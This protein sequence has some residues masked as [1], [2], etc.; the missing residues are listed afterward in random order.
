MTIA[1]IIPIRTH[2]LYKIDMNTELIP[3]SRPSQMYSYMVATVELTANVC[4]MAS[5]SFMSSSSS[6]SSK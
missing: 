3:V 1:N 6:S 2:I 5:S 4:I